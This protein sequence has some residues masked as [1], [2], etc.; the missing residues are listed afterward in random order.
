M[1]FYPAGLP[2]SRNTLAYKLRGPGEPANAELKTGTSCA[3]SDAAVES[4][5]T[6]Q[7]HHVLQIQEI[8]Q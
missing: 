5:A 4:R 1:L 6:S 2:L 8:E 7:S 3:N